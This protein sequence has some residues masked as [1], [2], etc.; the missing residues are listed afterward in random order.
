MD[1]D[2]PPVKTKLISTAGQPTRGD[3]MFTNTVFSGAV[4]AAS[5]LAPAGPSTVAADEPPGNITIDIVTAN[6]SGCP[7]GTTAVAMS[8]DNTAFT[9]TYSQFLA[10]AGGNA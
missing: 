3:L 7:I 4:L 1:L 5:L 10:Q 2:N 6:G 9:I 8:P